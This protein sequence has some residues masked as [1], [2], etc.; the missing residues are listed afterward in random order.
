MIIKK[1]GEAWLLG[2]TFKVKTIPLFPISNP[3]SLSS[4]LPCSLRLFFINSLLYFSVTSFSLLLSPLSLPPLLIF[5]LQTSKSI[6]LTVRSSDGRAFCGGQTRSRQRF[7][8]KI[9]WEENRKNR[10]RFN[11]SYGWIEVQTVHCKRDN[12]SFLC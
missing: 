12:S 2:I 4:L 1:E 10:A 7:F 6:L 3:S 9:L 11:K 8:S 5:H